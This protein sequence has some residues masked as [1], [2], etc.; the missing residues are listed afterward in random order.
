MLY[1]NER[2]CTLFEIVVS[3]LN[4]LDS[5][6]DRIVNKLDLLH[7]HA[8][9]TDSIRP[10][11]E[12]F[13]GVALTGLR[14]NLQVFHWFDSEGVFTS[15]RGDYILVMTS[16]FE[17]DEYDKDDIVWCGHSCWKWQD[18]VIAAW[19][20]V[21]FQQVR[22]I[23]TQHHQLMETDTHTQKHSPPT[24]KELG[25]ESAYED[26]RQEM[27][28]IA[29]KQRVP[30]VLA[31]GDE[32]L[33]AQSCSIGEAVSLA[34]RMRH[35]MLRNDVTDLRIH[36]FTQPLQSLALAIVRGEG[37]KAAFAE[38]EPYWQELVLSGRDKDFFKDSLHLCI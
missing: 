19:G 17:N 23:M 31:V 24:C 35:A 33:A 32:Y 10:L 30:G 1:S 2:F 25:I 5:R 14:V 9:Q 15:V 16:N 22:A 36:M 12:E 38:L 21:K 20:D 7:S 8:K 29:L 11:G 34:N 3:R 6:L 37:E 28:E 4:F 13:S 27:V 18:A 26:I